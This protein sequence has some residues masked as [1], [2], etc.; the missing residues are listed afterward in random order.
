MLNVID[1]CENAEQ[2]V[3]ARNYYTLFLRRRPYSIRNIEGMFLSYYAMSKGELLGL[4]LPQNPPTGPKG[5]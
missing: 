3:M 5:A 4:Q 1:S 2:L